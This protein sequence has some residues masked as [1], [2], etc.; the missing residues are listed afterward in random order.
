VDIAADWA[1]LAAVHRLAYGHMLAHAALILQLAGRVHEARATA[2]RLR[3][4]QPDYDA[5][6]LFQTFYTMPA[7]VEHAFRSALP[8]LEG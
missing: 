3:Q 4:R 5:E 6:S 2:I 1:G 8:V 7:E